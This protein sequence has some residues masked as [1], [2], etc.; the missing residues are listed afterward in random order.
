MSSE[1]STNSESEYDYNSIEDVQVQRSDI[2]PV[3]FEGLPD[4][5]FVKLVVDVNRK[6]TDAYPEYFMQSSFAM[7]SATVRRRLY[8]KTNGSKHYMNIWVAL[9]GPSSSRK[10]PAMQFG[11]RVLRKIIGNTFIPDQ[12]TVETLKKQ[13]ASRIEIRKKG[14]GGIEIINNVISG[15]IHP[16]Q[17]IFWKDE[18]GSFYSQLGKQHMK[19]MIDTLDDFYGCPDYRDYPLSGEAYYLED[20]YFPMIV[21]T[22]PEDFYR[23]MASSDIRTGFLPRHEIVIPKYINKDWKNGRGAIKE[24]SSNDEFNEMCLE[25]CIQIIDVLLNNANIKIDFE[26]GILHENGDYDKGMANLWSGTREGYFKSKNH[27]LDSYFSKYQTAALK[28]ATLIEIGNLPYIV[29][30][31]YDKLIET[32]ELDIIVKPDE[33]PCMDDIL[34]AIYAVDIEKLKSIKIKKLIV[35]RQSFTY[36]ARL[37]DTIYIPYAN[38]LTNELGESNGVNQSATEKIFSIMQN[39]RIITHTDLLHK[40][41]PENRKHLSEALEIIAEAEMMKKVTIKGKTKATTAYVYVPKDHEMFANLPYS[42]CS[43]PIKDFHMK[44]ETV[45][46]DN[47]DTT[48]STITETIKP[49]EYENKFK[50]GAKTGD[51]NCDRIKRECE[52]A[53]SNSIIH[54]IPLH[55]NKFTGFEA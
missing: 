4:Y 15:K 36:A 30:S 21:A 37:F 27:A 42:G 35:S 10:S 51:K 38:S 9:L 22:T 6:V 20:I 2:A 47:I 48:S 14:E 17:R 55:L 29:A 41:K 34:D 33:V 12:S 19:G 31:A 11:E 3:S 54:T 8:F 13:M 43:F 5:N 45:D 26:E 32:G 24:T 28:F 16:S 25:K 40:L 49:D 7:L 53:A 39:S 46:A 50:T 44:I 52:E 1:N 23:N 18:A